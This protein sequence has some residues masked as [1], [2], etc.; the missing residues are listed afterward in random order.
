MNEKQFESVLALDSFGRYSHFISKVA[1][2]EQ[3]WGI[4]NE[5][6]WLVPVEINKEINNKLIR[7]PS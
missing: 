7:H 5:E 4:K 6:G 3:L 1:D 2:W